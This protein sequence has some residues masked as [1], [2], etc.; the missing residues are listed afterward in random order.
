MST[1]PLLGLGLSSNL[2]ARVRPNP[3]RLLANDRTLFDFVEYSAPLDVEEAQRTAS[4]FAEMFAKRDDVRVLFHPVHL[5]LYGP[6]LEAKENLRALDRHAKAVGSPWVGN[7][8]GWWHEG[9]QPFPGYLYIPPPLTAAGVSDCAA[10]ALHV[11]AELS[12]PLLLENPVVIVKRG[13]LHVLDFMSKLHAKTGLGLILDMGH[14]FSH[15]LATGTELTSGFDGFPFEHVYE[16]HIAGGVVTRRA[17]RSV[18]FDDHTQPIREELFTL[19]QEVLPRCRNLRALVYEGDGHSEPIAVRTLARLRRMWRTEVSSDVQTPPLS[20]RGVEA[21]HAL[22][23]R[24]WQLFD[25]S[26]ARGKN[27]DDPE[28]ARADLDIRLCVLAEQLDNAFPLSRP[29]VA[30]RRET[31]V[32]FAASE[33][34]KTMFTE[35]RA[36]IAAWT[37]FA[38]TETRRD[39]E[40]PSSAALAFEIWAHGAAHVHSRPA[41]AEGEVV[42]APGFQVASFPFDFTEALFAARALKRHLLARAWATEELPSDALEGLA[43]A[44]KRAPSGP[45]LIV[46]RFL[47]GVLEARPIPMELSAAVRPIPRDSLP[48]LMLKAALSEGLL[49]KA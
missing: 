6:T 12:V 11:Q 30:P 22:E 33:D 20:V 24:P 45:W 1:L 17:D 44:V 29:L 28:G 8:V 37:S 49:I 43:Q 26:H 23:T 2:D 10:H 18:Y 47:G 7:D 9:G 13:D 5:N 27:V 19:L 40:H 36:L 21:A 14:L 46:L 35:G 31:L 34:F 41:P 15:A 3:Y 25:E 32:R 4:L 48:P 42:L 16:I 39:P 38:R